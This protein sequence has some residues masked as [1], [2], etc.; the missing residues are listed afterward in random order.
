MLFWTKIKKETLGVDV[1]KSHSG[2]VGVNQVI[3]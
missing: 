2:L 3:G 1:T